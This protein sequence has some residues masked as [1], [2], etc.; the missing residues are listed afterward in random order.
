MPL[1]SM[2][3]DHAKGLYLEGIRDGRAREA[4]AAHTGARYTQHSTGVADGPDG[5]IEFFESFMERNPKREVEIV[6]AIEDGRYVF[7]HV[8][9]SLNDGE[10]RWVSTDLFDTDE[11]GKIIEHW[12]V[13]S[14]FEGPGPSGHSQVD[15]T[16]EISDVELTEYNKGRIRLFMAEVLQNGDFDN[17][18]DY[19]AEDLVQHAVGLED[20]R[21]AMRYRIEDAH[22]AGVQC[23]FVFKLIGQGNFVVSYSKSVMDDEAVAVFNIWRL[24]EGKIA[25]HWSNVETIAPRSEWANSGKF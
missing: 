4:I 14:A 16:T 3:L 25:E 13:I 17:F 12:D 23:E 18:D 20:G 11:D 15:G 19:V 24:A 1:M 2:R 10:A 22:D 9:Q 5:F 8:Y 6:R 7:L 21:D